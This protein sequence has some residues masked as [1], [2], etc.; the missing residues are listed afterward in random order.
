MSFATFDFSFPATFAQP[1]WQIDAT[2]AG[3]ATSETATAQSLT[4]SFRATSD[5]L[6]AALRPLKSDEGKVA[7]VNKDDGG[8]V[9]VDRA[10]GANTFTL[11][12][13]SRRTPLRQQGDFH[14]RRYEEDLV[15]QDVGEWEVEIEFVRGADR[16]DTP[17]INDALTG[18]VFDWTFDQAFSRN[19]S[20]AFIT[21]YGTI[22]TDRVDADFLGTGADGVERF[23]L[24]TRLTFEEAHAFEAALSLLAGQ[25]VKS[26]PDA[27]NLVIDETSGDANTLTI[28]SPRNNE[29][30]DG[31]YVVSEWE[32]RRVTEA[33]Q[34]VSLII[35]TSG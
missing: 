24:T 22:A 17:S 6:T 26:V 19:K 28:D 2:G 9:A 25:R 34:E 8:F 23:E 13:P 32:S 10:N 27:P 16:T 35:G 15:S 1:N 30:A 7:V 29:V 11:E 5:T 18:A 20:W 4:L 14:V 21:R 3:E 12:P 31:D 33:Y